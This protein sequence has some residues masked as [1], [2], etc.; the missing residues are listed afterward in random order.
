M[1]CPLVQIELKRSGIE[2]KEAFSQINR[3][4]NI[5]LE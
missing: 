2:I 3:Y 4:Q 5:L 1:V